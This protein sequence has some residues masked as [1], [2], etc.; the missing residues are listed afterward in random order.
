MAKKQLIKPISFFILVIFL[1]V[2]SFA[3]IVLAQKTTISETK[4]GLDQELSALKERL[5]TIEKNKLLDDHNQTEHIKQALSISGDTV[6]YVGIIATV[7]LALII[8][9]IGY[10][11]IR[12]S[13]FEIE[14]RETRKSMMDEYQ[15][16]LNIRSEAEKFMSD[17]KDK[18][19]N[20]EAVV[21]DLTISYLSKTT[22]DLVKKEVKEQTEPV[23]AEIKTKDEEMTKNMELMK[24]LETL[25][26]TLTPSVYIERGKIY[27]DQGNLEKSIENFNR[28]LENKPKSFDA[29]FFRGIAY[30]RMSKFDEAINDYMKAIEIKPK[31]FDSYVN[32]GVCYRVKRDFDYEKSI[33][34]LSEA[35]KLNTK[36]EVIYLQR[37]ETY[38]KM[39]KHDLA[40]ND[41]KEADKLNPNSILTLFNIGF[42]YG[43]IGNFDLAIEYYLKVT[44]KEK[45]LP[46]I[47]NLSEAYICKKDYL[48]AERW[49]NE[50]YSMST[51]IQNKV[52]SKFLLVTTLILNNKEYKLELKSIIDMLR[53]NPDF[54]VGTW[55]FEELLGCLAG[56]SIPQEKT[57]VVKKMIALLKKEIRPEN[58]SI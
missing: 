56:T 44:E 10:Q 41:L 13:Q 28:S 43:R 22:P 37:G 20:L 15:K 26:L 12:S 39:K 7:V 46:T 45:Q 24:K 1:F 25:D 2:G 51:D 49:A 33:Q 54:K 3:Q 19:G 32:I 34:Y 8:F 52:M 36:D 11:V 35:I 5:E 14:I 31:N 23:I 16:I 53:D 17:T 21:G 6:K 50:S 42:N 4:K 9:L 57:E 38:L 58:F 47:M 29:Y 55:S 40:I 27:L 18:M 48:N 30:H